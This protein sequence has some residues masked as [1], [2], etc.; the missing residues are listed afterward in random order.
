MILLHNRLLYKFET[1]E[2]LSLPPIQLLIDTRR[3]ERWLLTLNLTMP[4][5]SNHQVGWRWAG[6]AR[7]QS[8]FSHGYSSMF[9]WRAS[10][11]KKPRKPHATGP[12]NWKPQLGKPNSRHQPG[13]PSPQTTINEQKCKKYKEWSW[14]KI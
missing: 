1:A 8:F 2:G 4:L 5:V 10:T 3:G 11:P 14:K 6:L 7:M 13:K 12:I 9:I